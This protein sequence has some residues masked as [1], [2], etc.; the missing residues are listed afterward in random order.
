[1][2]NIQD[3][4]AKARADGVPDEKIVKYLAGLEDVGPGVQKALQ[5]NVQPSAIVD[6]LSRSP[7]F[8]AGEKSPTSERVVSS[9]LEGPTFGFYDELYGAATAIPKAIRE[10]VSIPEAYRQGRDLIRGEQ[11]SL[12]QEQGA[13]KTIG[14]QAAASLPLMAIPGIGQARNM[15]MAGRLARAGVTGAG[16]GGLISAGAS[17]YGLDDPR[18]YSDVGT[19]AA[20]GSVLSGA[21]QAAIP[22]VGVGVRQIASRVLPPETQ[23]YAAQKVAQAITR[24]MPEVPGA[25]PLNQAQ[26]KLRALGSQGRIADVSA[27]TRSLL[28][29]TATMPGR[30]QQAVDAAIRQRQSTAGPRIL[31]GAEQVMGRKA[32]DVRG[33][34]QSL[35]DERKLSSAPFYKVV[36]TATVTVDDGMYALLQRASDA[37]SKA[38][39]LERMETGNLVDLSNLK[40]G[41]PVPMRVLD[42]LKKSLDDIASAAKRA[43]EANTNRVASGAAASLVEKLKEISPKVGGKSAYSQALDAFA[44][45]SKLLDA[46]EVGRGAM[47][48]KIDD[49]TDAMAAMTK[50]EMDAFRLGAVQSLREAAGT[51]GGRTRLSKFW[52]EPNTSDR[53]KQIFGNDYKR[54]AATLLQEGKMKP[55]ESVGKGSKTAERLAG[56]ADLGESPLQVLG[57]AAEMGVAAKTG[58]ASPGILQSASNRLGQVQVP[59]PVRNEIG[60]LLLSRDPADFTK[61]REALNQLNDAQ[62]QQ[63]VQ[64]GLI[65][66]QSG[67]YFLDR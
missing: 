42:T 55:F 50:S 53:L 48:L 36:D 59:E 56:Q 51:E 18:F 2:A 20:V 22:A 29:T 49:L 34:V 25:D 21:T 67:G 23:N 35:I 32:I 64:S 41:D 33:T 5:D 14:L 1:M 39:K 44:G 4:I 45:P 6:F 31:S 60:R 58:M 16:F 30:T 10:G 15:S 24:G 7:Q 19:G 3:G 40:V 62:R 43:G 11:A 8:R 27:P 63:L 9:A 54:F 26:A 57:E 65:G 28:D 46:V 66:G 52:K 47:K 38:Q 13:L 61:L 37:Q 17:E 12:A